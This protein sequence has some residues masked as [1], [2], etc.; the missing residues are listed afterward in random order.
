MSRIIER[1]ETSGSVRIGPVTLISLV[2]ILCLAVLAVLAVNTARANSAQA[3]R[4][5]EFTQGAYSN[6]SS[7][8]ELLRD[9]DLA[10]YGAKQVQLSMSETMGAVR[11]ACP[12][13]ASINGNSVAV[14]FETQAGQRLDIK[15]DIN[16]DY[17]YTVTQ[18]TTST[19][20]D[21]ES[22]AGQQASGSAQ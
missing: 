15:I 14:A 10:L 18:W 6:D 11:E 4:Q 22:S 12:S 8:Q 2:V 20:L 17:S 3:Q 21:S 16:S 1:S 5:L 13:A 9:I 7:A 19:T